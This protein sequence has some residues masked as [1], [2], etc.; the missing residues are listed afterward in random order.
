[1]NFHGTANGGILLILGFI[2]VLTSMALWWRDCVREGIYFLC[3]DLFL[4]QIF[5]LTIC[6][7]IFSLTKVSSRKYTRVLK[8]LIIFY[9]Q[10]KI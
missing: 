9:N 3:R 1:M 7:K 5:L 4:I 2:C 10:Q 6:W 8:I